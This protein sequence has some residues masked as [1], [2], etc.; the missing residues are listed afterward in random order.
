MKHSKR[1]ILV[2]LYAFYLTDSSGQRKVCDT[3]I[4]NYYLQIAHGDSSTQRID[5]FLNSFP[6][7]EICFRELPMIITSIDLNS[8]VGADLLNLYFKF[9]LLKKNNLT[10]VFKAASNLTWEADWINYLNKNLTILANDK[11]VIFYKYFN[12]LSNPEKKNIFKFLL[13]PYP[14]TTINLYSKIVPNAKKNKSFLILKPL[15]N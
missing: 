3:A 7:N 8:L 14:K 12:K 11:P 10:R 5:S 13:G 2:L 1:I 4:V 9:S 6:Y 15:I